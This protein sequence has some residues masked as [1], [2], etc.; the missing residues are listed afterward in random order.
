ML[1]AVDTNVV[2]AALLSWHEFHARAARAVGQRIGGLV[3]PVPVLTESYSVMTRLPAPHR[4]APGDAL[5]LLQHTFQNERLA[6]FPTHDS[7]RFLVECAGHGVAGGRTY[8]ALIVRAAV[9]A[10]ATGLLTFNARDF[11]PFESEIAIV[12]P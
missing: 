4:L 8:D 1:V 6:G 10:K 9:A 11:R 3:L 2:V 7:W 5:R 12:I